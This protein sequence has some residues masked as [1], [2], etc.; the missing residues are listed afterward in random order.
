[1]VR[2]SQGD[3]LFILVRCGVISTVAGTGGYARYG[4]EK[5]DQVRVYNG[6]KFETVTEVPAGS[7]CAVT[8]LTRTFLAKGWE[9]NR[10][11]NHRRCN[12]C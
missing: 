2:S 10:T 1:M 6:A 4:P 9:R 11:P 5:V 3:R 7:V 12:P 8:G